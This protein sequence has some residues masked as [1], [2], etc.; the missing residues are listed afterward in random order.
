MMCNQLQTGKWRSPDSNTRQWQCITNVLHRYSITEGLVVLNTDQV[1]T[2]VAWHD[3]YS[4]HHWLALMS[5]MS[6]SRSLLSYRLQQLTCTYNHYYNLY[7]SICT[8][9]HSLYTSRLFIKLVWAFY[10]QSGSSK[11]SLYTW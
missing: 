8:H 3:A 10:T 11:M 1:H 9:L 2:V 5:L 6:W 4:I 7:A